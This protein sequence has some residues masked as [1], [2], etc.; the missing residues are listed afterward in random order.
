M[1]QFFRS[2]ICVVLFALVVGCAALGSPTPDTFNQK[3]AVA[4]AS[5]SEVRGTAVT[6]LAVKKISVSDAKNIQAQA[7]VAR[8]GLDVAR[9]MSG[10]NLS[11]AT[12]RLEVANTALKALQAY[13]I[14]KQGTKP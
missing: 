6:L 5:V 14:T 4:V 3:L 13:L 9:S 7:D 8:E 2:I 10:T 1:K 12:T 11:D